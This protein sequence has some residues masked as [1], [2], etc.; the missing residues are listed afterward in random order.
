MTRVGKPSQAALVM[1]GQFRHAVALAALVALVFWATKLD[2]VAEGSLLGLSTT[3]WLVLL[4]IDT[5]V[6]QVFVWLS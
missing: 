1:E 3:A 2:G 4:V 6:H 5:I